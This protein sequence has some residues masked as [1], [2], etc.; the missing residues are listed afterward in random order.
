VNVGLKPRPGSSNREVLAGLIERVTFHALS[1]L[2]RWPAL[3][4]AASL[5]LQRW[6]ELDGDHYKILTHAADAL[7]GSTHSRRRWCCVR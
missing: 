4:R 2:V 3:D 5:V 7:A 6:D 1:F